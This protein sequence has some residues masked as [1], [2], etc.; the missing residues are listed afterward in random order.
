MNTLQKRTSNP[1]SRFK[2]GLGKRENNCIG[3]TGEKNHGEE[4]KGRNPNAQT[5][6]EILDN[7]GKPRSLHEKSEKKKI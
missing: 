6:K 4:E 1:A 2:R 5:V 3:H 7:L